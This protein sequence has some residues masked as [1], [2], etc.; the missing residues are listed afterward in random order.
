MCSIVDA[1]VRASS[2]WRGSSKN[3]RGGV[4]GEG[5]EGVSAAFV[6]GAAGIEHSLREGGKEGLGKKEVREY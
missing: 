4:R 5:K 1:K 2:G 6:G 3:I